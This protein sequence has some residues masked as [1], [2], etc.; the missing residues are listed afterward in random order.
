MNFNGTASQLWWRALA[1]VAAAPGEV[2][3]NENGER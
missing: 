1:A 3:I 2:P